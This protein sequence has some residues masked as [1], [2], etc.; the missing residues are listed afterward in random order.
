MHVIALVAKG[1]EEVATR[2]STSEPEYYAFKEGYEAI[3]KWVS[4]FTVF[5][6]FDHKNIEKAHSVFSSR[7]ASKK[8]INWIANGKYKVLADSGSRVA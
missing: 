3:A 8:L 5:M 1:F 6:F 4:D 2:W 7:R